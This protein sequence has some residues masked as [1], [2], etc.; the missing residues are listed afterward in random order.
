MRRKG[1]GGRSHNVEIVTRSKKCQLEE[2]IKI[3]E[4]HLQMVGEECHFRKSSTQT[5]PSEAEAPTLSP[6]EFQH[7]S[8]MPPVPRYEYT[9]RPV[10][11]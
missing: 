11:G 2:S 5:E 1:D 3:E 6:R 10:Y 8:K 9:T 4:C 7:T